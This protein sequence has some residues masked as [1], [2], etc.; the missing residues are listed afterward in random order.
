MRSSNSTT[1]IGMQESCC[2]VISQFRYIICTVIGVILRCIRSITIEIFGC[3]RE[4]CNIRTK[5][6]RSYL[7]YKI[8]CICRKLCKCI[9]AFGD[10][11]RVL[12]IKCFVCTS[13]CFQLSINISLGGR[14]ADH[15]TL[16]IIH[17]LH[18]RLNGCYRNDSTICIVYCGYITGNWH[19][20]KFR[21]VPISAVCV[22][23][24]TK[25]AMRRYHHTLELPE[26]TLR[27]WHSCCRTKIF[28]YS[29]LFVTAI[30]INTLGEV[31]CNIITRTGC[32]A[33]CKA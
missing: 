24:E 28:V 25:V 19:D 21:H 32:V 13:Q 6:Y 33:E 26:S 30:Y 27:L 23:I 2:T 29:I 17:S 20:I 12:G 18:S 4:F 7:V 15:D 1:I 22:H 11:G 14:C 31:A 16:T 9:L 10:C 8:L 5:P 3:E